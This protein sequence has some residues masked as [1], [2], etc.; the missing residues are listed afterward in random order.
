LFILFDTLV[1]FV[2]RAGQL[3]GVIKLLGKPLFR[4]PDVLGVKTEFPGPIQR[5]F[6][7]NM[8]CVNG[9]GR[10]NSETRYDTN[11]SFHS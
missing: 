1:V 9:T 3:D 2:G 5:K 6:C 7:K 8:L 11:T 4:D 10:Q